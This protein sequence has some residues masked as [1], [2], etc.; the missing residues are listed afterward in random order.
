MEFLA[1]QEHWDAI[2]FVDL[3]RQ[4]AQSGSACEQFCRDVQH[5][6]W[7]LLF[8]DCYRQAVQE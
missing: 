8:D 3:C 4:A 7:Q 2:R 1:T 6:E 5:A